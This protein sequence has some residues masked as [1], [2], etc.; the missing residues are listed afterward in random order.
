MAIKAYII[1][2][3]LLDDLLIAILYFAEEDID[4]TIEMYVLELWSEK[5]SFAFY[6]LSSLQQ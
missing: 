5:N 3:S 1:H 6:S 2:Y 4:W